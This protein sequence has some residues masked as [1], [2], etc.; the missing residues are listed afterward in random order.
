MIL[1]HKYKFIFFKTKKT[2]STSIELN[3]SKICGPSDIITPV[4]ELTWLGN[5]RR[6]EKNNEED[7]DV[8]KKVLQIDQTQKSIDES[9]N[10][11]QKNL[12]QSIL[13]KINN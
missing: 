9:R 13:E 11:D 4:S 8:I 3:L 1:S 2:G 5:N 10:G 6:F 7:S 12:E